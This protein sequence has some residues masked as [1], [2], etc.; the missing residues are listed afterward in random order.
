MCQDPPYYR[1]IHGKDGAHL[2]ASTQIYK[3]IAE[4]NSAIISIIND[5]VSI[6]MTSVSPQ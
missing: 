5:V 6:W 3:N 4:I 2:P 1:F